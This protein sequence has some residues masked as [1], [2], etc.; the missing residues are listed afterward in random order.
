MKK[1]AFTA[2]LFFVI[3]CGGGGGGAS[4]PVTGGGGTTP[5]LSSW[6][7]SITIE[8]ANVYRTSEYNSQW[9]LEA[10]HAA[11]AYAVLNKNSKNIA[12]SGVI[13]AVTDTGMQ[14]SHIE[15]AAATAGLTHSNN[16]VS[17]ESHA[18]HVAGIIAAAKNNSGMEGVAYEAS[19]L[20]VKIIGAS[21]PS[22]NYGMVYSVNQ[23]AKVI[24]GSWGF[25]H[26][27]TKIGIQLEIGSLDYINLKNY[28][29]T[30]FNSLKAGD[31]LFVAAAGNDGYTDHIGVPALFAQDADYAG[32]IIAVGSL[33]EN[34]HLSSFSNYCS[35]AKD[36][37][38]VAPGGYI[39]SSYP[40]NTYKLESG[41]SMAAP[42]V[43]GAAAVIRGAWP[44][45]TAPQTM[46]ILLQTASKN[47]KDTS[48]VTVTYSA[49][50]YGQGLLNLYAAVQ[51]Q[52]SNNFAYGS[53]VDSGSYDL[54]YSSMTTS[55][56]FGD[57]F[58]QNVV[59]QLQNAVF[60]DDFG[61]DYKAN[62]GDKISS[63]KPIQQTDLGYLMNS[64]SSNRIMPLRF[65]AE[66]KTALNFNLS[67]FKNSDAPNMFGLKHLVMDR[68]T[69]PQLMNTQNSGFSF[70]QQDVLLK[71]SS[72]GFA[73]NYD[74]IS[75]RLQK[76]FGSAG[77]I[78]K[79]N[80]AAAPF[81]DFMRQ[82]SVN[83]WH[84]SRKFNQLF[85]D[86]NFLN[87]KFALKFS[88]QNSYE[89]AQLGI[90]GAKQNEMLDLGMMFKTKNDLSFLVSAG[91][92]TEFDN[93]M[94]NSR[95]VGAFESVGNVKTSY[96]KITVAKKFFEDFQI[97][98]SISEGISKIN[99]NAVGIFRSFDNVR[100]RSASLAL[101]RDNFMNGQIGLSYVE[102]MRVY[103][104]SANFDIAVARDNAGNLTRYQ[105]SAS[106]APKGREQDFEIFYLRNL[107]N[108][109]NLKMN[110]LMQKEMAN[111]KNYPTN[112][113]G[114]VSYSKKF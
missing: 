97:I 51:A 28:L 55:P 44:H 13:V 41:T 72:A 105:G 47:W 56:I 71:N 85:M 90:K 35:Q 99:G 30:D 83:L 108:F 7:S 54:R 77:F 103:Q 78:L 74:E 112:Y 45:L 16:L 62:L 58:A 82:G 42:H 111:I 104:G 96:A 36:Y 66:K 49:D 107:G 88:Y 26:T 61:R 9:G 14:T 39:Y 57:A 20:S 95:S 15:L 87:E 92:L 23:G 24:N 46:Q 114:F 110:F 37:C 63:Y 60:F 25:N 109:S 93:N 10:I 50:I 70:A 79:N 11:E 73:F 38:L 98:A 81:Q 12:G 18:T 19:I 29:A 69:D 17:G 6:N 65:G 86:Q 21:P 31:A 32:Y 43:A 5:P 113:L 91:N 34:L 89:S 3:S 59:P 76:D 101:I 40:T 4:A 53:S 75:S 33:D 84:N 27:A 100:S 80:F 106:L 94:L 8:E 102:P 64:N 67:S 22:S 48:G 68:S 2:A 52:G 1:L